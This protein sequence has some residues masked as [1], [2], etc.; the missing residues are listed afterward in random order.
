MMHVLQDI[1][2]IQLIQLY[3]AVVEELHHLIRDDAHN[4]VI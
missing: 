2:T 1:T 3:I 4:L